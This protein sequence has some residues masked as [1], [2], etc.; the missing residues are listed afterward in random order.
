MKSR[1]NHQSPSSS[2][3]SLASSSSSC[4]SSSLPPLLL[5]S[6]SSSSSWSSSSSSSSSPSSSAAHARNF[7]KNEEHM[8][9]VTLLQGSQPDPP[10]L[11]AH[12]QRSHLAS[13]LQNWSRDAGTKQRKNASGLSCMRLC[14]GQSHALRQRE[15]RV[16]RTGRGSGRRLCLQE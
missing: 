3:S 2:T 6:S 12:R 9:S 16:C 4:S 5:S 8:S 14:H 11:G 10:Y 15:C 7:Y 13:Q 1:R